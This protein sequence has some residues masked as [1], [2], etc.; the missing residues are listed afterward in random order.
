MEEKKKPL[1][2]HPAFFAGLQ[3][4]LSEEADNLE[5]ENE[6]Q[7]GTKP[8]QIDVL[9]IKKDADKPIRKNIGRIFRRHNIVEYKSP[10]DYLSID[11]FYKVYGY[12]CFY[13]ADATHIDALKIEE[14][15]I[16]FVCHNYPRKLIRHLR[17][18]GYHVRKVDAGIYYI[19]G[20]Q[21]PMQLILTSALSEE[22]NLW[23]ANL[24]NDLKEKKTAKRILAEYEKHKED[25][26]YES[27]MN[28]ITNANMK[29]FEEVNYMCEALVDIVM[30]SDRWKDT[31]D[32]AT[33][34]KWKNDVEKGR[35]E[36]TERVNKLIQN[37][38]ASS[39]SG[40]IERA[41]TDS[42]YQQCLFEE[43]GL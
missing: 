29:L 3:I 13:K 2:W 31:L 28:L 10:E 1:Q 23:L 14:L 19:E 11:D 25:G 27:V 37:L 15:T 40:E 8:K 18:H 26:R 9:V 21:M 41:V 22:E 6:H 17:E 5:F 39:R 30:R 33:K 43:F 12:T 7:L 35:T 16:S 34:E 42:A 38:I 24:T 32:E 4:E 20:L 36:G